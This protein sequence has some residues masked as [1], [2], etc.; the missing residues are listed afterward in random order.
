MESGHPANDSLLS[1]RA[2]LTGSAASGDEREVAGW[3]EHAALL[4]AA[5]RSAP[6]ILW[7]LDHRGTIGLVEG[8]RLS[9]LGV[10][11]GDLI[12]RA[13]ADLGTTL[14][15][16][17]A[18]VQRALRGEAS[19]RTARI[20]ELSFETRYIP[21][22]D[23]A[24]TITGV[25]C[26]S[27]D[28]TERASYEQRLIF[29]SRHDALTDLPNRAL[30]IERARQA[31]AHSTGH[32]SSIAVLL[33]DIDRFKT[34][35]DYLGHEVGDRLLAGVAARVGRCVRASD[36]VARLGGDEFAVLLTR[37]DGAA[38]VASR[39]ARRILERLHRPF[40]I[41]GLEVVVTASIGIA[42]G[43]G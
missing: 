27:T 16:T 28:I 38:E 12:G 18:A 39:I 20:G 23:S 42:P 8:G 19:S 41:D 37:P 7:A 31:Q 24:G 2:S 10:K 1:L 29:Q 43:E 25:I 9:A 6:V 32:G 21:N 26:Y 11:A 17:P 22:Y 35:N 13:L 5:V 3:R 14:P 30:F 36:T 34:V 33:L 40:T 4:R 15:L